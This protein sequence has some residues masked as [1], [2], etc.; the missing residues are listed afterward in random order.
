MPGLDARCAVHDAQAV[1]TCRRCGRFACSR[2]AAPG[3]VRCVEC[4]ALEPGRDA[5]SP[6]R[7]AIAGAA[8]PVGVFLATNGVLWALRADLLVPMWQHA[9]GVALGGLVLLGSAVT[10]G[11]SRLAFASRNEGLRLTLTLGLWALAAFGAVF[12]ALFAPVVFAFTFGA[13]AP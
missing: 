6:G 1:L 7:W 11:L 13:A 10:A 5:R 9:F 12:T 4:E 2:C 8:L 3:G